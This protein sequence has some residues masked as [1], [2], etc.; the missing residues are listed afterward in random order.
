MSGILTEQIKKND[1]S[2]KREK[3][4]FIMSLVLS[5]LLVAA[6]F[7]SFE[8]KSLP[9]NALEIPPS[10]K[11]LH[12][13][14]K[15]VVVPLTVL[16]DFNHNEK[17]T[18]ISLLNKNKKVIVKS[19]FLHEEVKNTNKENLTATPRFKIEIPENELINISTDDNEVMVAIPEIEEK[20]SE[21]I[22]IKKQ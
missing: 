15:M 14:Y 4:K 22:K 7:L 9:C 2:K 19:A 8:K 18:K 20:I 21:T 6:L 12:P 11:Q 5:N 13:H 3:L 16:L 1:L 17:E 10:I